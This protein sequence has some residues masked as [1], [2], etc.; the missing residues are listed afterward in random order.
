MSIIGI[1]TAL[2]INLGIRARSQSLIAKTVNDVGSI[3]TALNSS[4][5]LKRFDFS[6]ISLDGLC[7]ENFLGQSLCDQDGTK[8]SIR[9]NV[10]GGAYVLSIPPQ[11][12]DKGDYFKLTLEGV[13]DTVAEILYQNLTTFG[14]ATLSTGSGGLKS[15][16]ICSQ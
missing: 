7:Q 2:A 9:K 1:L 16:S 8:S 12:C 4:A 11:D 13:P 10:W 14:K 6:Q 15:V 3:V 5:A